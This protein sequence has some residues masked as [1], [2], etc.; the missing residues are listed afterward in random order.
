M[1]ILN[2]VCLWRNCPFNIK[3]LL[4]LDIDYTVYF[5]L[6]IS[7]LKSLQISSEQFSLRIKYKIRT[8]NHLTT[9]WQY[10]L[11]RVYVIHAMS[12]YVVISA[13]ER[14][15]LI[16]HQCFLHIFQGRGQSGGCMFK[17]IQVGAQVG[18]TRG[19]ALL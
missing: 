9:N 11:G 5:D 2:V 15:R 13:S 1:P 17:V 12:R 8:C 10:Y 18:A 3:Y 14:N 4:D 19:G 7:G 6:K 16:K